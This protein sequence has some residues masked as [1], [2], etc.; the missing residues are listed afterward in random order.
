MGF[1]LNFE[2]WLVQQTKQNPARWD[3]HEILGKPFNHISVKSEESIEYTINI[4][5]CVRFTCEWIMVSINTYLFH[6]FISTTVLLVIQ[7]NAI[8][9]TVV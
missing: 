2:D 6:L 4:Q 8:A 3:R 5:V 7:T 9:Y 1:V